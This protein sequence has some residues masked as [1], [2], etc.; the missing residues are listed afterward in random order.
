MA[1][2]NQSDIEHGPGDLPSS[3]VPGVEAMREGAGEW[4]IEWEDGTERSMTLVG[5]AWYA[6]EFDATATVT[7]RSE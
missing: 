3:Q 6:R 5:I 1:A 2:S 7:A 4:L